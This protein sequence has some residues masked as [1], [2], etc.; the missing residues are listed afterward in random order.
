MILPKKGMAPQTR[1]QQGPL[2]RGPFLLFLFLFLIV[3]GLPSVQAF[4]G[5]SINAMPDSI[6]IKGKTVSLKNLNNPLAVDSGD[7]KKNLEAGAKIYFQHCFLCHGDLMD[8]KGVFGDRFFPSPANFK[9][10]QHS[11]IYKPQSY[12]YWRIMKGGKGLPASHSPWDSAMPAWEETLSDKEVWQVISFIYE[13]VNDFARQDESVELA[14][15]EKRGK[16][17][18]NKHCVYC[19]GDKADGKGVSAPIS[20]PRPRNFVKGQYKI[21]STPFGKIPT[22]QDLFDMLTRGYPYTTMP[23]WEHLSISDRWSLVAYLKTVSKKFKKFVAKKRSHKIVKVPTPPP[24][25][26]ES[27]KRGKESFLINCS[28]CHG[29]EG[30][31]DGAST[32]KI[33]AVESDALW[34]RNLTKSWTF[35]R[36]NQRSDLYKTIRTGL[37]TTAMPRF[38]KRIKDEEIWDII[39]FVQTLSLSKKPTVRKQIKAKKLDKELPLDPDDSAW[40]Q[41][42]SFFVPLGGQIIEDEKAHY[43]HADN[44]FVKAIYNKDE[45]ALRLEWHDPNPDP[46]LSTLTTV[47]ESPPP[48]LPPH[49]Q[50]LM[51]KEEPV[52][53]A[54]P[55]A[56]EFPDSIAVQFPVSWK[57][58]GDPKPY[59]LNGDSEHPVNLWVWKSHPMKTVETNSRGMTAFED[60]AQ[61]GQA[62]QSKAVYEFGEYRLVM[63]RKLNTGDTDHDAQFQAGGSMP[64]AFNIWEGSQKET[65]S[66]KAISSWFQLELK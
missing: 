32:K 64:I 8:G 20:S 66:K 34:P 62:V 55:E 10:P 65:G 21:R 39:H 5:P 23:A 18:Y 36:G 13:S 29:K 37:S 57:S 35:R 31:A 53:D 54:P 45:I 3:F 2:Q 19:H 48:P 42:D 58:P 61:T 15:S 26:L 43:P 47:K 1:F 51:A 27:V 59:F 28:G 12:A 11:I 49:L 33:V 24:F 46:I 7:K 41:A 17:V 38:S 4:T 44:L 30:R 60:Q 16:E 56:A 6:S 63:K 40:Q 14:P 9:D 50:A 22:D 52:E 25:S